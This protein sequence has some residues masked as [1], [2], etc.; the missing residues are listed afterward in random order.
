MSHFVIR[1]EETLLKALFSRAKQHQQ[2]NDSFSF[3]FS[4]LTRN[5]L[6]SQ[7]FKP[8]ST[9]I[10]LPFSAVGSGFDQFLLQPGEVF[11]SML[12]SLPGLSLP[13]HLGHHVLTPC[14]LLPTTVA[15][16]RPSI[17]P[18]GTESS[19]SLNAPLLHRSCWCSVFDARAK[20]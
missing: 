13:T 20:C 8:P 14:P 18:P 6:T 16:S 2:G 3:T 11:A 17:C 4:L 7:A 10:P 5:G 1:G 12:S 9:A 15:I 19:A